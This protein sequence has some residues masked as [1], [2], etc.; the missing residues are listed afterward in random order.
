MKLAARIMED[1]ALSKKMDEASILIKRDIIF[2]PSL[3]LE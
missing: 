3:Y 1:A 2:T